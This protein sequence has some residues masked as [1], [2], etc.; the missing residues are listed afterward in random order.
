[1]L[2]Y[3]AIRATAFSNISKLKEQRTSQKAPFLRQ[4]HSGIIL[5]FNRLVSGGPPP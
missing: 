1:M 5:P 4:E 2:F 3:I